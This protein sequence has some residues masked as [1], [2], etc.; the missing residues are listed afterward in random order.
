MNS[1]FEYSV[2]TLDEGDPVRFAGDGYAVL[3]A[4]DRNILLTLPSTNINVTAKEEPL[5]DISLALEIAMNR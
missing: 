2:I 4:Y 1:H 3:P 5:S